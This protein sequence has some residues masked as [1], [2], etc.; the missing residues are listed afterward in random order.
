MS[1]IMHVMSFTI[2]RI[3]AREL[4]NM[5]IIHTGMFVESLLFS[6]LAAVTCINAKET[7]YRKIIQVLHL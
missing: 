3:P 2:S 7:I 5:L 1:L 6:S 4:R